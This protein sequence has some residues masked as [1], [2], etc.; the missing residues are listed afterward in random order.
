MGPL[1]KARVHASATTVSPAHTATTIAVNWAS[2][3]VPKRASPH[4]DAMPVQVRDS[5]R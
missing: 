3:M 1:P 4:Q 2:V 5:Q